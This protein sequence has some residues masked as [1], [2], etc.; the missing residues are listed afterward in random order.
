MWRNGKLDH[1]NKN[2]WNSLANLDANADLKVEVNMGAIIDAKIGAH[3]GETKV[4]ATM[5]TNLDPK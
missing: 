1:E 2:K 4:D 5:D 3:C